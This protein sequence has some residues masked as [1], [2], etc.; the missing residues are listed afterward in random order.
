MNITENFQFNE[1]RPA[2][3][4]VRE[5][6]RQQIIAIGLKNGQVLK[7]HVSNI[8]AFIVVL[9]GAILFEMEGTT[10]QLNEMDTFEIPVSVPHEVTGKME[11][12]F[13]VIKEKA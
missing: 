1:D 11:S 7:K 5:S 4:T 3:L 2:V 13:L 10:T 8:P 6:E 12:I 9:R